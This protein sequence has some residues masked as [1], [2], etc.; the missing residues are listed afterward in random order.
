MIAADTRRTK[1]VAE[2]ERLEKAIEGDIDMDQQDEYSER[3][4]VIRSHLF[5]IHLIWSDF[6]HLR[7]I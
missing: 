5:H 2:Q 7:A 1:L 3:I 6:I 4:K